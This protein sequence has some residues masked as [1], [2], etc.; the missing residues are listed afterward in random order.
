MRVPSVLILPTFVGLALATSGVRAHAARRSETK[1]Q[2]GARTVVAMVARPV[3]PRAN[4]NEGL[5]DALDGLFKRGPRTERTLVLTFDDGP[6][7]DSA[8]TLLDTL[9]DLD[10]RATFFVVG[11]RVKARPA[12]V[13]RMLAEGHEVGNHTED[14]ARLHDLPDARVSEELRQCEADVRKATGHAMTLMRPPGMRFTPS[15]LRIARALGYVTVDYN[16]VAGDYVPNG[17]VSDLTPEEAEAYG[18][19]P[20]VL[21]E[22]VERQFKPGTIILLHDNPVTVSAVP[23]IVARARAQGYRFVTTAEMLASLPDPVRIVANP[24]AREEAK[25]KK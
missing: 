7:P 4:P 25:G 6:H 20:S 13:R 21:V 10:V 19:Q 2:R 24:I 12:L 15:V 5:F 1:P 18:L 8:E 14:H 16:N 22:R 11:E 23:E 9:R 17:G 3:P